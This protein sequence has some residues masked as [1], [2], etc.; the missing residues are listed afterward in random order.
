MV[1]EMRVEYVREMSS[2]QSRM[3]QMERNQVQN[4][5][6]R[7][8]NNNKENNNPWPKTNPPNDQRP[9]TP[10]EFANVVDQHIPFCRPCESFHEESV[11]AIA[12]L[13]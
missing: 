12:N 8:N 13:G 9:P 7:N 3:I 1:K 4:I 11:C 5:Q 6:P 10:L 2:M